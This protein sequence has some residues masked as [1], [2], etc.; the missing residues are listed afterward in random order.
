MS[1]TRQVS[2]VHE[3]A[4]LGL[5]CSGFLAVASSQRLD[6]A[7]LV[8]CGAA[9]VLRLAWLALP[10]RFR[11]PWWGIALPALASLWIASRLP[12]G[13]SGLVLAALLLA[14]AYQMWAGRSGRD[15]LL[16]AALAFLELVTGA[17]LA[18]GAAYFACLGLF[19]LC[20]MTALGSGEIRRGLERPVRVPSLAPMRLGARL[21]AFTLCLGLSV[22]MLTAGLFLVLPRTARVLADRLPLLPGRH[23]IRL[24]SQVGLGN[25][26]R[27][28]SDERAVLHVKPYSRQAPL[29]LKWRGA[30]LSDFDGRIWSESPADRGIL[31]AERGTVAVAD[32][33]QRRRPGARALY[34]VE[35]SDLDS[36]T[37]FVAGTPE[38]LNVGAGRLLQTSAATFRLAS[39][40]AGPVRYDVSSFLRPVAASTEYHAPPELTAAERERCLRL[41]ALDPRIAQL[42]ATDGAG[43]AD[44]FERAHDLEQHLRRDYGY[45]LQMP[46]TAPRDPLA[47]F[48]FER[49][50]GHCEYFAS[51]LAV[52]LRTQG[53]PARLVTGFESGVFNPYSG[54]LTIRASDA[55][56]WVEAFL[57]G[58]GWTTLDPTPSA[59]DTSPAWLS[60]LRL[61]LD[62]AD[63]FWR[64]W[65]LDYDLA[66]QVQLVDRFHPGDGA[67][68]WLARAR[69][70]VRVNASAFASGVL[71]LALLLMTGWYWRRRWPR[72]HRTLPGRAPA[73]A[74]AYARMLHVLARYGLRKP[75]SQTPAE[76]AAACPDAGLAPLLQAFTEEYLRLRF[77]GPEETSDANLPRH[78]RAMQ[79]HLRGAR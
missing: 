76:F 63:S 46:A 47:N 14:T 44:D 61:R 34:R 37:L 50:T 79:A 28:K 32:G 75:A 9:Y 40:G 53:I 43:A 69:N 58:R 21:T 33:W 19:L 39:G 3:L 35:F 54:L 66:R 52:M 27:L 42:A 67:S 8:F 11:I 1:A 23:L 10:R 31:R 49:R 12:V 17:L 57:K 70:A 38:F 64:E 48:L 62:A 5:A 2:T 65:V 73:A 6:V 25:I 45:T 24:T 71:V 4:L 51:A 60:D 13:W 18:T 16:T 29:G 36:D 78:L 15:H 41:P 22:L 20:A 77:A 72:F 55:H 30:T 59:A 7:T 56:S 26:G 68:I 74:K